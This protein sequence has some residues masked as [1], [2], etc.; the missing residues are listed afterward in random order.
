M[1]F[2]GDEKTVLP[3]WDPMVCTTIYVVG[4]KLILSMIWFRVPSH[5]LL[6]RKAP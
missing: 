1:I 6:S 2:E 3:P 5:N 4:I